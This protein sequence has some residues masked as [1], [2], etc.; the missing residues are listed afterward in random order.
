MKLQ[1]ILYIASS[2]FVGG[3]GT[4]VSGAFA[5]DF[6]RKGHYFAGTVA[7]LVSIAWAAKNYLDAKKY[8]ADNQ[9]NSKTD[10]K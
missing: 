2:T 10:L 7:G 1:E 6:F 5:Y 4:T 9:K 8:L 3:A